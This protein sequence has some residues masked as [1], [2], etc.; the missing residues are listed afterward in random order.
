MSKSAPRRSRSTWVR[1]NMAMDQRKLALA[2]RF[3]GTRTETE[4]V[5]A[6]LDLL[7]FQAE[8]FAGLDTVAAS[9]AFRGP[10]R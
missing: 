9:G 1:K 10:R 3:L 5:D 8:V 7:A 2:Q 6:A 4:T